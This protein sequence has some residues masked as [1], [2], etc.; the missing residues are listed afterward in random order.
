MPI[1]VRCHL[2]GLW[3]DE[4]V[5]AVALFI[6]HKSPALWDGLPDFGAW[7]TRSLP[8]AGTYDGNGGLTLQPSGICQ[9]TAESF[10]VDLTEASRA[11]L[12]SR[13]HGPGTWESLPAHER[14][15]WLLSEAVRT[16]AIRILNEPDPYPYLRTVEAR[17]YGGGSSE[18]FSLAKLMRDPIEAARQANRA[19]ADFRPELEL[20]GAF[21]R[22]DVW[23]LIIKRDSP[24]GSPDPILT[25][26]RFLRLNG[27]WCWD[28]LCRYGSAYGF[29]D[30]QHA[31]C[32]LHEYL[33]VLRHLCRQRLAWQPAVTIASGY[34]APLQEKAD[35]LMEYANLAARDARQRPSDI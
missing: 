6:A 12:T 34:A 11:T 10:D 16:H 20:A 21:I 1:S 3:I 7:L 27:S 25:I 9:V 29:T 8:L 28:Q 19:E 30:R 14:V 23:D 5:P 22:R 31:E 4:G 33:A 17:R 13:Y 24:I 18:G 15:S 35:L 26:D 2:S 32:F